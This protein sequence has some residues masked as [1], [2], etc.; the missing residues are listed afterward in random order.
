MSVRNWAMLGL[1]VVSTSLL[2]FGCG[3]G[4]DTAATDNP[5]TAAAYVAD[6]ETGH[7]VY[8]Q[9]CINCHGPT[10]A[11]MPHNGAALTT[12]TFVASHTDTELAA[13][14][15][16]G[17]AA[18]DPDN[19]SGVAM[20]ANGNVPGGLDDDRLLDVVAFLRQIQA[21]AK[22]HPALATPATAPATAPAQ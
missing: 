20:P 5:P 15:K 19:K 12:S 9:A 4:N 8:R 1:V 18:Y 2:G 6:A 16:K 17:R 11:G 7:E 14:I 3:K 10:G 22:A 21:K 13:F